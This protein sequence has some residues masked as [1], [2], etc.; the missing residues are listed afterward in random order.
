VTHTWAD[1]ARSACGRALAD[2][3]VAGNDGDLAGDHHVG[4]ALDAVDQR[5]AAAVEVV[6]LATW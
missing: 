2:V 4:G 3:A 6:E 1:S 5:F